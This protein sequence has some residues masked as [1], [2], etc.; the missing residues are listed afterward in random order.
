MKHIKEYC[1]IN[2]ISRRWVKEL[3]NRGQLPSEK[4]NGQRYIICPPSVSTADASDLLPPDKFKEEIR[5]FVGKAGKLYIR[6]ALRRISDYEK[7]T[8]CKI[9][10][11]SGRTLYGI[12]EGKRSVYHRKRKDSGTI[13]NENLSTAKEKIE[14]MTA[15]LYMDLGQPNIR[16][17]VTRLQEIARTTESLYEIAAIPQPTLYR[18]VSQWIKNNDFDKCYEYYNQH[19]SFLKRLPKV[20][21]SFSDDINFMDYIAFDDRKGDVAGSLYYDEVTGKTKLRKVWYWIAIEMLTM[22][23][24]G[25]VILPREPN[26]DDVINVLIQ[27]MMNVG[28]PKKGYL[29]D[30]GIGNSGKVQSFMSRIKTLAAGSEYL[31]KDFIPVAP[32]EPTHKANIERFNRFI[33]DEYDV[34]YKNYVGGNREEVRHSGKRLMPEECDHLV[35]EY[36]EK[37]NAYLTGDCINRTRDR[38]IK[39]KRYRVSIADLFDRQMQSYEPY[40][41]NDQSLRWSLM[42]D[43]MIKTYEGGISLYREGVRFTYSDTDYNSSLEGRKFQ[44][45]ML[46]SNQSKMDLYATEDFVDTNTG[47]EYHRGQLVT[48]LYSMRE[49]PSAE[50]QKSVFKYRKQAMQHARAVKEKLLDSALAQFPEL[51]PLVNTHITIDGEALDV[52]KNLLKRME[53]VT[54][55]TPLTSIASFIKTEVAAIA[56]NVTKGLTFDLAEEPEEESGNSLTFYEE[57]L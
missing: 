20:T 6:E 31:E 5:T 12:A 52:R 36:I 26:S 46:P 16:F 43:T 29:F 27:S 24:V 13:R 49:L 17:I 2:G 4:I 42:D 50:R 53:S 8:G 25:W 21:G 51:L 54:E 56:E 11:L 9:K 33:K 18:Y 7:A 30:N 35:E 14:A 23:P 38:V 32:Y 22:K 15:K 41:L 55:S 34:I 19:K 10:G 40:M 1:S 37:A 3:V 44:I 48:T 57:E 45:A 39:A 28:L 47:E